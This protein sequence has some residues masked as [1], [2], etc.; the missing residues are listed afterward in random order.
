MSDTERHGTP[1]DRHDTGQSTLR[2]DAG[3]T[4]D[5]RDDAGGQRM[6][7]I[8]AGDI[9]ADRYRVIDG[10]IGGNTG[11]AEVF[12]CLDETT[13]QTVAFKRYLPNISP[14][15]Q[16]PEELVGINHPNIVCLSA[17]GDWRQRFFEVMEFCVGGNM[18]DY[19]PYEESRLK[20]LLRQII[21]GLKFLHDLGIIHRD[22]KPNN[23]LFRDRELRNVVITDFGSSS[24]LEEGQ[25]NKPSSRRGTLD[26][27]APEM[28]LEKEISAKTDYYS[29][30]ISLIHLLTG[31][32]PF[33]GKDRYF[34]DGAHVEGRVQVPERIS[35]DMRILIKGLIRR[36]PEARWGYRQV[37]A[38]L[39]GQPVLAENGHPDEDI[40]YYAAPHPFPA[41]EEA[42]NPVELSHCLGKFDAVKHLFKGDIRA[43]VFTH[44]G[45][46]KMA[47]AIEEIEEHYTGRKD[48]G[49]FKLGFVL[50]PTR[51]LIINGHTVST[52]TELTHLLQSS[53]RQ[54]LSALE[55]A[56]WDEQI[57]AW[58]DATIRG[59][60]DQP[61][62]RELIEKISNL[63][64]RLN[65]DR[66]LGLI[67][68]LYTLD[69]QV[70]FPITTGVT[71]ARPE[72]VEGVLAIRP[73]LTNEVRDHLISGRFEEWIRAAFPERRGDLDALI[74]FRNDFSGNQ[75]LGVYAMRWHF[76]HKVPFPFGDEPVRTP[77]DLAQ[78]IDKDEKSRQLGSRMLT[79]GWIKTWLVNAFT[80]SDPRPFDT[81]ITNKDMNTQAKLEAVLQFLDPGMSKPKVSAS[82]NSLNLG[83]IGT[84]TMKKSKVK[85]HNS[86]RGYLWGSFRIEGS[87][88]GFVIDQQR[89]DGGPVTVTITVRPLGM[90]VGSI[91]EVNLVA[92]TNVGVFRIPVRYRVSA[93][94]GAM[95]GRSIIAGL[96]SASTLGFYRL[97]I[98]NAL[99][100]YSGHFI[101]IDELNSIPGGIAF[102][103][104]LFGG[105]LI[106][107][108]GGGIYYF[109][110][111][112]EV[113]NRG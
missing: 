35:E 21:T 110:R 44:F 6:A 11:E 86:G 45:D 40:P 104:I 91:Q 84:E 56:L 95:I 81:I 79:E 96:V 9:L 107:G 87:G 78:M 97:I 85:I 52:I 46:L 100:Q 22:I 13:Q 48:L 111:M 88:A 106:A 31:R 80:L 89:I 60:E 36:H 10:P 61:K 49:I 43:W 24:L 57:E 82:H 39:E 18:A 17:F 101:K 33:Y 16:I 29:L 62:K 53:E 63:R 70:L 68:L 102:M 19:M 38:W 26:Y 90:P 99:G 32:S 4:T 34:I 69:P 66:S 41:C 51:P 12:R 27:E 14:K 73:E 108:I 105:L 65:N 92:D 59:Q 93:P 2:R 7:D 28:I 112:N 113:L 83:M 20:D 42:T 15:S 72:Y 109:I 74:R 103:G 54:T 76:D 5:R 64:T 37:H 50:D 55:S 58:I 71:I 23:L 25:E 30:G 47:M 77:K 8:Q 75:A 1:T 98:S 3:Q 67:S 94:I